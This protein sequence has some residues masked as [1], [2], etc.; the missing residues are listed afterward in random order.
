MKRLEQMREELK[1][2]AEKEAMNLWRLARRAEKH[3]VSRDVI[4]EIREEASWLHTTAQ[5]Y[6]DRLLDWKFTYEHKYAFR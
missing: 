3:N 5:A 1:Q 2:M 6:P 4:H